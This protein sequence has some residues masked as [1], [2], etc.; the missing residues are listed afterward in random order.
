MHLYSALT[1]K[2]SGF[3]LEDYVRRN[4][5]GGIWRDRAMPVDNSKHG[6]FISDSEMKELEAT[7]K[8]HGPWKKY[9][10]YIRENQKY[11]KPPFD[12]DKYLRDQRR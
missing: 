5:N 9:D 8:A 7:G 11:L 1:T 4:E 6:D 3:D 10:N 12:P 2:K